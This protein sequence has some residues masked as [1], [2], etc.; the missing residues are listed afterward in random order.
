MP[1]HTPPNEATNP[2]A[3]GKRQL[4]DAALR[5][6]A[7]HQASDALSLRELARE[8]GLN[9]NTFYRHFTSL[10]Q[11][12]AELMSEFSAHLRQGTRAAR[13]QE[14][15]GGT[16]VRRVVS[17]LFEFA[18]Q[19]RELCLV[20]WRTLHGPP[21]EGRLQ[22]QRCLTDLR[23]D[24]LRDQRAMG[25]LPPGPDDV[26]LR[27]L[28]LY[29]RNVFA[30]MVRYLDDATQREALLAE[31]E[32]LLAVLVAGTRLLHPGHKA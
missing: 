15:A 29:G 3:A 4:M 30:L 5:L 22:L 11:L 24:M 6:M 19:H 7:Q 28:G 8:A 21:S 26:W 31:S 1:D 32:E 17:W 18:A 2:M 9:H 20:A 25:L 13:A 16:V 14:E 27:M 10:S 12:Q 23:D